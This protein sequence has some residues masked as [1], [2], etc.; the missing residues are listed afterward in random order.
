M[1]VHTSTSHNRQRRGPTALQNLTRHRITQILVNTSGMVEV[2]TNFSYSTIDSI[3]YYNSSNIT[4]VEKPVEW[5]NKEI[6]RVIQS[7]I[8]PILIITGTI[9]NGLTFYIMR[10]TSLKHLSSCF[11]MSILAVADTSK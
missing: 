7:I 10:R 9:G 8:R 6:A 5:T 2:E 4:V 3:G 11:Y 1:G